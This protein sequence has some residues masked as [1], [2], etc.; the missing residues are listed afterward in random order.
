M[1]NV[2][3]NSSAISTANGEKLRFTVKDLSAEWGISEGWIRD[4]LPSKGDHPTALLRNNAGIRQG[5]FEKL[6]NDRQLGR[7][8]ARDYLHN[9][10]S[11]GEIKLVR[12]ARNAKFY[13]LADS[14]GDAE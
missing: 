7:N 4:H 13:Y 6:A 10:L 2:S 9:R 12:G 11:A 5:D 3:E 8:H 1:I 14:D